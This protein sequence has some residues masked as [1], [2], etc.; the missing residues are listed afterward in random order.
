MVE[1]FKTEDW[2]LISDKIKTKDHI[3]CSRRYT[4]IREPEEF[5]DEEEEVD[6]TWTPKEDS[7]LIFAYRKHKG[8]WVKI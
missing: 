7:L 6:L 3:E 4:M 1:R 8:N 5:E 2:K